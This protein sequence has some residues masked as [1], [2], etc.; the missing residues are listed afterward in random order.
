MGPRY[1]A[2]GPRPGVRMPQM[3][4]DFNGPP[5]QPMMPNSMDPTRQ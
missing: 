2:A 3:G 4:N 5:G 1:P